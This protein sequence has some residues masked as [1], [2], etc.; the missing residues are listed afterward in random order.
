MSYAAISEFAQRG[1][2]I[3]FL[4]IFVIACAYAFWPRNKAEFDKAARAP[5]ED[6]EDPS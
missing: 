2:S 4:S 3:Y 6:D 1:G 5:L